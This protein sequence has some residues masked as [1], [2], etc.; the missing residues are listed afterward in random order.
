MTRSLSATLSSRGIAL[1][2]Y[3]RITGQTGEDVVAEMRVQA[4]DLVRKDLALEAVVVAEGIHV[5]DEMV[6]GWVREQAAEAEEDPDESVERLMADP[7][8]LTAL[9]QDL[10][11]Q[12][13]LDVVVEHAKP[14]TAEQADAKQKLWTPEKETA[15]SG[16]KSSQIWTPGSS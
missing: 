8:T 2:D 1:A 11:A 15:Q 12:R 13:A 4:E 10:A 5:T 9:R 3:L 6:E 14:I 16:A 7:A